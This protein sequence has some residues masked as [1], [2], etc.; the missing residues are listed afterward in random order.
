MLLLATSWKQQWLMRFRLRVA[1][2]R[3][4]RRISLQFP[5]PRTTDRR[6]RHSVG[7]LLLRGDGRPPRRR[8]RGPINYTPLF[9]FTLLLTIMAKNHSSCLV[10][11]GLFSRWTRQQLQSSVGT[12]VTPKDRT[13]TRQS[14][15]A[16]SQVKK[17]YPHVQR[18]FWF[19][20]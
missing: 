18:L 14:S 17:R 1:P 16:S 8:L 12:D 5:L 2:W 20:V 9:A 4:R 7:A 6:W 19:D 11:E 10:C 15:N 13:L 3:S